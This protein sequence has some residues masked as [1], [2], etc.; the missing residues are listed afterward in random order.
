M[1]R[2]R[3]GRRLLLTGAT[4]FLGSRLLRAL[5]YAGWRSTILVRR[6]SRLDRIR[7]LLPRTEVAFLDETDPDIPCRA[8][9][10]DAFLHLATD[11]GRTGASPESLQETNVELPLRWAE[12]AFRAGTRVIVNT[13]TSLPAAVGPYARTKQL[14]RERLAE[15]LP[16]AVVVSP[17]FEHFFGPGDDPSKFTAHVVRSLLDEVP[18]LDLTIGT[19][20]R[21]FLYIDDA[22]SAYLTLLRASFGLPAGFHRLSVGGGVAPTVREFVELARTLCGNVR[23]RLN[24]G[25]RPLRDREVTYSCADPS[26]LRG[27]GWTPRFTWQEGLERT[28]RA[29]RRS[30]AA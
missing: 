5:T 11:Y 9:R 3:N 19:Q 12:A 1:P 16:R 25:A 13:D 21:D 26:R 20:R 28:V 8:G 17:E 10:F 6:T 2:E 15:R 29:E 30:A 24:F 22:V 7:D 23:T 27:W 4:G 14:C 18:E